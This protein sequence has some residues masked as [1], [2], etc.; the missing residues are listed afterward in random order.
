VIEL[1]HQEEHT[2]EEIA[3]V[4]QRSANAARKLWVRAIECLRKEIDQPDQ[5]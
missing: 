1:R 5:E 4:M 3:V 2:F